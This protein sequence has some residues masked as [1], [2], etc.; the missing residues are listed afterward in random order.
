MYCCALLLI[1]SEWLH[2]GDDSRTMLVHYMPWYSSKPVSGRWGWHWTMNHFNPDKVNQNGRREVA[3][4]DYPLIGPYDSSDP[5]A[6]ECHVL[7]MKFA[8]IDGAIIDWYG[9][10]DF[11]DYA[12]I[13]RNTERL[14][15][16]IKK[17][18]L[19]YA[20]C[21]EDQSVK[22]MI[23]GKLLDKA[24]DIAHGTKVLEWLH[25]NWFGDDAYLKVDGRPVM[26][27]FG[28]QHFFKKE[29]WEQIVSGRPKRPLLYA[30]PHLSQRIGADGA[31]GWPP[32]SGGREAVPAVWRQY[33]RDLYSR[34]MNGESII[35]V[36]FPG[37]HD[38]YKEANLHA[39]YGYLDDREGKTFEET[40]ELAW[41]SK[42]R[43]IQVATWNDYGEGTIIEPTQTFGYRYLEAVQ[44]HIRTH[45]K[46]AVPFGRDDL[47]L[48]VMLY[49][50][51]KGRM[52]DPVAM[53]D[54]DK[55]SA[56]LFSSKCDEAR[57]L[58]EKYG[59]KSAEPDAAADADK[60]R[61]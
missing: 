49:E 20:V 19:R 38:I 25:N 18:G 52:G 22:H 36:V 33:L 1:F 45:S 6:L 40:L 28:P 8:G 14:I 26:L 56:L 10:A 4:H 54:L 13:H 21:Y 17:A 35:A 61:P 43:L 31:F 5:H 32:V 29:Q 50:L 30:L 39:G 51:R 2:A 60:P 16:Y 58:L 7:L 57:T 48:P 53:R 27:L 3:S 11:R 37:F 42:S 55:A 34:G 46:E 44:K 9:I 12:A 15:K 23:K 59:M 24:E 47:R 41:R